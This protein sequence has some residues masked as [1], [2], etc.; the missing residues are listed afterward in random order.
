MM[1]LCRTTAA[2]AVMCVLAIGMTGCEKKE[3]GGKGADSAKPIVVKLDGTSIENKAKITT[4]L[5]KADMVDGEGDKVVSK[6]AGCAL[7]MDGKAS[8]AIEC[9]GYTLNFCA[10]GCRTMFNKDFEKSALAI[11]L[12]GK[13]S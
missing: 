4:L 3:G 12:P 7:G 6:C 13:S 9:E 8:Y 5:A 11:K 1:T 10:Y 2:V